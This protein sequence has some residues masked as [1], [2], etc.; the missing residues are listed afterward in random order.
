MADTF[1]RQTSKYH[2]PLVAALRPLR[3]TELSNIDA[4]A[5]VLRAFPHLEGELR[6]IMLSDHSSNHRSKGACRCSC[7]DDAPVERVSYGRYRVRELI[8]SVA[9]ES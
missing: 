8:E 6:W 9:I 5:A 1:S 4:R 3:G 2:E 7:T